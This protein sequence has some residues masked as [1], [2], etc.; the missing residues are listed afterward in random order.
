MHETRQKW[1][2]AEFTTGLGRLT[3][4]SGGDSPIIAPS[5]SVHAFQSM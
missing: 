1:V 5:M 3:E 4:K 2:G